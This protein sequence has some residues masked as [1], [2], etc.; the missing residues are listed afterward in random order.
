MA[1]AFVEH[2]HLF[3]TVHGMEEVFSVL[4]ALVGWNRIARHVEKRNELV[5]SATRCK[6]KSDVRW[7]DATILDRGFHVLVCHV[8]LIIT[9]IQYQRRWEDHKNSKV[10]ATLFCTI[11][12]G[13]S[14]LSYWSNWFN[15]MQKLLTAKICQTLYW[16][17]LAMCPRSVWLT[18]LGAVIIG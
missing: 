14:V 7:S 13:H 3:S 12:Y 6:S 5:F 2:Q 11:S 17:L 16:K 8:C 4:V 1:G 18:H 15:L 9:R 10:M